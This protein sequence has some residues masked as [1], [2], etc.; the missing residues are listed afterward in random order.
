MGHALGQD[1]ERRSFRAERLLRSAD[2]KDFSL[3]RAPLASPGLSGRELWLKSNGGAASPPRDQEAVHT[4]G[5]WRKAGIGHP[6]SVLSHSFA[7][8]V[9][10]KIRL[11]ST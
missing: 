9:T 5:G 8:R 6:A 1:V 3:S 4:S 11:L 7:R 2:T 10:P